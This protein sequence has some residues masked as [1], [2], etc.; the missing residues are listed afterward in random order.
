MEPTFSHFGICVSDLEVSLRF[1]CEALGFQKAESHE[2]GTEFAALMDF[3]DVAVTSQF[4]RKGTTAIELLSFSEPEPFGDKERRPVN[5]LG[6]THLSF[7]VSDVEAVAAQ[8]VEL[9]GSR[10]ASSRTTID[11]AG[12]PLEFVYCT[13]PDGVR[14][15]LMDLGG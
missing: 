15:E 9:G 1:Y 13:D 5:Q 4:I 14:I 10:V 2:I 3:E 11:F 6:L 7:R 12:T 8:V